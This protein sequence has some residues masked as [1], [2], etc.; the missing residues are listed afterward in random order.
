MARFHYKIVQH[1]G[2]W[3]YTLD[4]AYSEAFTSRAE[5]MKA[6]KRVVAEQ[7]AQGEPTVI[8]YQ[9]DQGEWHT[10]NSEGNDP[11]DVDVG[12]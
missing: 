7:H 3:A 6:V 11:T 9:D 10:E 1:D 5:A 8:E 4:G 12:A 2:G